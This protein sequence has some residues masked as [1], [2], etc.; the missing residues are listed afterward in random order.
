MGSSS[1]LT[2]TSST[3][4]MDSSTA[5]ILDMIHTLRSAF[6]AVDFAQV[7]ANLV[8]R[9]GAWKRAVKAKETEMRMIKKNY[10]ILKHD[11]ETRVKEME[12]VEENYNINKLEVSKLN[13]EINKRDL[14]I[15]GLKESKSRAENEV[16][17]YRKKF[18]E[19]DER[20]LILE[21]DL[22]LNSGEPPGLKSATI[23]MDELEEKNASENGKKCEKIDNGKAEAWLS[24][25]AGNINLE[26]NEQ[27]AN[28]ETGCKRPLPEDVVDIVDSDDDHPPHDICSVKKHKSLCQLIEHISSVSCSTSSSSDSDDDMDSLLEI[29]FLAPM[30][31]QGKQAKTSQR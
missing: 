30:F 22:L 17:R 12:I 14:Q 16:E 10:Q 18:Q 19:L 8:A 20:I 25:T 1:S 31:L 9:E 11:L 23:S 15:L 3:Q 26:V 2:T 21:K 4:Q 24:D 5:T 7:E 27:N 13:D 6:R 29:P 28:E